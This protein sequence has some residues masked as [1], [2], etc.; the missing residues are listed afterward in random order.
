MGRGSGVRAA[1]AS[2]IAISFEYRGVQCREKIKLPP[3]DANLKFVRNLKARIDYEIAVGSFDYGQHFPRSRRAAAFAKHPA[4]LLTVGD[5]LTKWLAHVHSKLEP[6]TYGD[7][8]EYVANTWRPL[9]GKDRLSDLTLDRIYTDWMDK[10]TCGRKRI[11]NL[12][13]PLREAVRYAVGTL[14]LLHVDPIAE[15]QVTRPEEIEDEIVDPFSAAEIEAI[16]P[17]LEP[18]VA[19][20]VEFWVWS[21]PREGEVIALTWPDVDFDRGVAR[22]NKT[23]RGN[24]RKAPK[25]RAGKREIKLLPPALEALKRQKAY[26]RLLHKEVFMDPG[27]R[28]RGN[29][30]AKHRPPQAWGNDK[31]IR[32]RWEAACAAAGVRYRPPK[33]LRHTYATWMLM[34][35]EDPLWVSRQMGHRDV[36]I[37]LRIYVKYIPSMNPDAG[38]AAWRAITASKT[39]PPR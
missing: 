1:S 27:T 15:I 33:Q 32:V 20:M 19:N 12:L 8:A 4:Q 16:L 29:D 22:I 34:A 35:R 36:S 14:K 7:Y 26:T 23:A 6:E 17:H 3:N 24:R 31:Q 11:L 21:G 10:Q 5:L 9:L 18:E 25:T 30:K 28:P 13:T 38:M 39:S 2:S 37:T